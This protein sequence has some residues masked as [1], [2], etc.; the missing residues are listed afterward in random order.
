M[1]HEFIQPA[2]RDKRIVLLDRY[3]DSTTAYQGYGR[4]LPL[5]IVAHANEIGSTGIVPDLSFFIDIGWEESSRRK[6]K[7]NTARDQTGGRG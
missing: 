4:D 3:Y 6:Q 1:V 7:S 5:E 2:L